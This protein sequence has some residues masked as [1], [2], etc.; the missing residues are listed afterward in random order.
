MDGRRWRR[1]EVVGGKVNWAVRDS[2]G[3]GCEDG[4]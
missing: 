3:W 1:R 4:F 2:L